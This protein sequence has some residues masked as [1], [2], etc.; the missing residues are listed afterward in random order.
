[1][2]GFNSTI[3]AYGQ[4]GSG[5]TFTMF[6]PHWDDNMGYGGQSTIIS[7]QMGGLGSSFKSQYNGGADPFLQDQQ[8][9]GIIPRSIERLFQGLQQMQSRSNISYTV[10]CSFL[11]IYNEK[12]FDL[13]QDRESNKALNIREDKYTG[14]FVEGQSEYV[15]TNVNDCFILLKRGEANRITRQTRSNIHSSRS[16]TIFQILVESDTP[17]AG[18]FLFRGKLN[19]CD[20]AGSEKIHKDE[21]MS[22]QHF[23][24]L[25]TINLSLSSLGK[26]ISALA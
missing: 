11:Q 2:S 10:Y 24:E 22:G 4:T 9:F 1:M 25:K 6:G 17:D 26:V 13:F 15:V 8:Q 16:H 23:K 19:L 12:L 3:F 14:I 21:S 7:Y 18:G 20:L 5:K